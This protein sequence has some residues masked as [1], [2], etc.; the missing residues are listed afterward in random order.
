[1]HTFRPVGGTRWLISFVSYQLYFSFPEHF[2]YVRLGWPWY[3]MVTRRKIISALRGDLRTSN[4]QAGVLVTVP[5]LQL[6]GWYFYYCCLFNVSHTCLTHVSLT[7]VSLTPV[8]LTRVSH[9]SLSHLP[10]SHLPLSR[11]SHIVLGVFPFA[12]SKIQFIIT[13]FHHCNFFHLYL[14]LSNINC[15][16]VVL[17]LLFPKGN[18]FVSAGK[19]ICLRNFCYLL[20]FQPVLSFGLLLVCWDTLFLNSVFFLSVE[21]YCV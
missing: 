19:P 17:D 18:C 11:L 21:I 6:L 10:F 5:L 16:V 13:F 20:V 4:Q 7:P 14:Y 8:S 15:S 12:V 2:H 1:M 9:L 3:H